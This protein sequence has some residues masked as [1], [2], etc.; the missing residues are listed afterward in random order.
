MGLTGLDVEVG[1][2]AKPEDTRTVKMLIDS[3]ALFSVVARAVLEDLGIRP[4]A[5]QQFRLANGTTITREKGAAYF[6]YQNRVGGADVI[7]GEEN[8]SNLLGAMTLAS[9]GWVLDPLERELREIPMIL[10]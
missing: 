3:G 5:R 6:R 2:L 4:I 8:D 7:F 10:A 1:N 9:L